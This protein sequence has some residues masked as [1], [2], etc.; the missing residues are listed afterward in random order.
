M[1]ALVTPEQLAAYLQRDLDRASAELAIAGASGAARSYC[2]WAI[3]PSVEETWTLDGSGTPVLSL[4]TLRLTAVSAVAIDGTPVD[5]TTGA[6][7]LISQ[8]AWSA[9]GQ[10]YRA[11]GWPARFACVQVTAVHAYDTAPDEVA[12]VVLAVAGRALNN[13]EGLQHKQVGQ[14]SRSWEKGR[15]A[16]LSDLE[17]RLLDRYRLR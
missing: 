2:Q 3:A 16:E 14:V 6:A 4:P 12:L 13:P 7:G 1:D 17:C 11:E 15:P 5:P 10:L 8:Y 9:N